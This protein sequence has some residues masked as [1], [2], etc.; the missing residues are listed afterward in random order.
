ME[1][2]RQRGFSNLQSR[3][4]LK[5]GILNLYDKVEDI[6]IGDTCQDES[7]RICDE[8]IKELVENVLNEC[9]SDLSPV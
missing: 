9:S 2:K 5:N 7:G 6:K 1:L 8:I 4:D 3:S